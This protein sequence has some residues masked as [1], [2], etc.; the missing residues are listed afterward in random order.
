MGSGRG[1]S[2]HLPLG[3]RPAVTED[4]GGRPPGPP[5]ALQRLPPLPPS[6][7]LEFPSRRP[8]R[9]VPRGALGTFDDA[10]GRGDLTVLPGH[11]LLPAPAARWTRAAA[12]LPSRLRS[13]GQLPPCRAPEYVAPTARRGRPRR[14]RRRQRP[15]LRATGSPRARLRAH[16]FPAA[17]R[18][19][20]ALCARA[21][22]GFRLRTPAAGCWL[23]VC[24]GLMMLS[25]PAAGSPNPSLEHLTPAPG[26]AEATAIVEKRRCPD[27]QWHRVCAHSRERVPVFPR[28]LSSLAL[29]P[30]PTFVSRRNVPFYPV[31]HLIL[32]CSPTPKP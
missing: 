10:L 27:S 15:R 16:N 21:S 20:A 23:Q 11:G 28:K 22:L 14:G 2:T 19:A 31:L 5:R 24:V 7:L 3:T 32:S 26:A 1:R 30:P 29:G 4:A 17:A 9:A 6:P 18:A 8:T 13:A 25:L 12:F